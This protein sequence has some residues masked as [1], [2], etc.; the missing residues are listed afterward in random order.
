MFGFRG[1]DFLTIGD[2]D[3]DRRDFLLGEGV[4]DPYLRYVSGL[5]LRD[6]NRVELW[7]RDH[8]TV[9]KVTIKS[10]KPFSFAL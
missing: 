2:R 10:D 8:R 3:L 6:L 5:I 4:R 7:S 1:F 9:T